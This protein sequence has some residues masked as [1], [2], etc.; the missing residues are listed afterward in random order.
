MALGAATGLAGLPGALVVSLA[1]DGGD[2]PTG[3]ALQWQAAN[4]WRRAAALGLTSPPRWKTTTLTRSST[5]WATCCWPGATRTNVV[6]TTKRVCAAHNAPVTLPPGVHL[7]RAER[8]DAAAIHRLIWRERLNLSLSLDWRRFTL[9]VDAQG[10]MLACAQIKP[11][12]ERANWPRWRCCR[13][14]AAGLLV[15]IRHLQ[16]QAGPP[17]S[18]HLP[19]RACPVLRAAWF[20]R[21]GRS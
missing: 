6:S 13:P 2:G 9:A 1:T 5:R 20:P 12:G 11:H 15:L 14:G 16:A 7:R 19:R 10:R 18:L 8:T 4:A 21:P 17:A 3:A